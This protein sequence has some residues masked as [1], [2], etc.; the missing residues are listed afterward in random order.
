LSSV[1]Q[2]LFS[3]FPVLAST[4]TLTQEFVEFFWFSSVFPKHELRSTVHKAEI[5]IIIFFI[6][7]D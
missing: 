7:F 3:V 1:F 6:D 4:F 2:E 5:A